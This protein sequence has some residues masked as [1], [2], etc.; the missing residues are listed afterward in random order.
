MMKLRKE[1]G[2]DHTLSGVLFRHIPNKLR[3][4]AH[5]VYKSKKC[6]SMSHGSYG[7]VRSM[8]WARGN[9]WRKNHLKSLNKSHK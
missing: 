4:Y 2:H 9:S 1:E 5:E 7:I 8:S 3:S 6:K